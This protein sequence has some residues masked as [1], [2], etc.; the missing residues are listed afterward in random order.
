MTMINKTQ[1]LMVA[2]LISCGATV[3]GA[4]TAGG[5][6]GVSPGA[7]ERITTVEGRCPSFD[8]VA[9]PQAELYELAVYELDPTA[10]VQPGSSLEHAV[11]AEAIFTRVAG[12]ATG[13]TPGLGL[14]LVPGG[15][16]AWFVRAIFDE[17]AEEA[18]EWSPPLIFQV[19]PAPSTA[20]VEAALDV[21]RRHVAATGADAIANDIVRPGV[22]AA[23][24]A[25]VTHRDSAVS[26]QAGRSVP[27]GLAAILGEQPDPSGETYGVV[28][29]SASAGGAGIGAAN[30][31]GGADLVLDGSAQGFPDTILTESGIDRPHASPQ[32]ITIANSAGGG[33]TLDVEGA[34]AGDGSQLTDITAADLVCP[35]CVASGDLANASVTTTK[36]ADNSITASK[37]AAGAVGTSEIAPEAVTTTA[38][39]TNAVTDLEIAPGAVR[40]SELGSGAVSSSKILDNSII[41]SDI[42]TDGVT[43][44]EIA[45]GAVGASEIGASA[46][47]TIEIANYAVTYDKI[48]QDSVSGSRII[49]SSVTTVDIQDFSIR[50]RDLDSIY[51]IKV[52]CDGECS[53]S[54]LG[55]L[56]YGDDRPIAISCDGTSS[57]GST[58]NCGGDNTCAKIYMTDSQLLSHFCDDGSGWDALVACMIY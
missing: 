49:D 29:V 38:I 27:T 16:Y 7:A 48:A 3:A 43:A 42:A 25:T 56:C 46:V 58:F 50:S 35:G 55:D 44:S 32:T 30:T 24:G 47:N 10:A 37:I 5:P 4:E 40:N 14:C 15:R 1:V 23:H 17:T 45:A 20:E 12:G 41:A 21:L 28:G 54:T 2:V 31:A 9:V 26:K 18:G 52:E 11:V 19:S 33:M 51:T 8:W 36:V 57:Y 34:I 39:A 22:V 53:D 13:W 6:Q